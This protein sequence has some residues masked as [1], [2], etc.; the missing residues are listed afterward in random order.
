METT[1]KGRTI[2]MITD[3]RRT[4]KMA[5]RKRRMEVKHGVKKEKQKTRS[6]DQI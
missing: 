6:K 2:V 4:T 3:Q 5:G 1:F